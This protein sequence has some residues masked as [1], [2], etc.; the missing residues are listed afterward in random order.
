M[1]L[2]ELLQDKLTSAEAKLNLEKGHIFVFSNGNVEAG[3]PAMYDDTSNTVCWHSP[4]TGQAVIEIWGSG[5]SA[6]RM[7][8]CGSGLPG[9]A[10]AYSRKI[11]SVDADS[12]IYGTIGR[13]CRNQDLCFKGCSEATC[14]CWI[15]SGQ[16]GCMCAEGGMGGHAYC[17][18]STTS[19]YCCYRNGGFCA[20]NGGLS[21]YCGYVCNLSASKNW[22]ANGYGG[23]TNCPGRI[24]C[25]KVYCCGAGTLNIRCRLD[26]FV[27]APAGLYGLG[28]GHMAMITGEEDAHHAPLPGMALNNITAPMQILGHSPQR[29]GPPSYCWRSDRQCSC[30]EQY[31]CIPYM[32][33]GW[34]APGLYMCGDIRDTGARGGS[35]AM[36][37]RF[38][39]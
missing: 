16:D 4:G 32:P 24:S 28:C 21:S 37:I 1:N 7:C 34:G 20:E 11:I 22:I 5:G 15:G 3:Y 18:T 6:P 26:Y 17:Q 9:N 36:R 31:S 19:L 23:D 10:A 30:Y 39:A 12:Y 13:A 35:G 8:C 14:I 33:I 25:L 29:G 38:I 2:S 27:P